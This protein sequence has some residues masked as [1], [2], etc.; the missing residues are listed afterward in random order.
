MLRNK[1][2]LISS[3]AILF[4]AITT[5]IGQNPSTKKAKSFKTINIDSL[6][7]I[8]TEKNE[9]TIT[10]RISTLKNAEKAVDSLS[11]VVTV[12]KKENQQLHQTISNS[13]VS[14]NADKFE[15]LPISED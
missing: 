9:K 5:A 10:K 7:K 3:V 6:V 15:L 13:T 14:D 1:I 2:I 8:T 11:S 4:I 12:L